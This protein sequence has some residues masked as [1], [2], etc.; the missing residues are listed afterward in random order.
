MSKQMQAEALPC[1]YGDDRGRERGM[2]I[3]PELRGSLVQSANQSASLHKT[4]ADLGVRVQFVVKGPEPLS[5]SA[6][7]SEARSLL[8]QEQLRK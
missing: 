7:V 2:T 5:A 1:P 8:L 4:S 3:K 6:S